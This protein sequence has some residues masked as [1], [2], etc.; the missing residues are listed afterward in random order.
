MTRKDHFPLPFIDKLLERISGHPFYCFLDGYLG[1]FQIKIIVE[2]QEKTTLTCPFGTYAYKRRPF[3]LYNVPATFQRCM[4]SIFN[5]MVERI[6]EVYMDDITI[7]G[8][9]F[10]ECLANLEIVLNRCI[11]KTWCFTGRSAILW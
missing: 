11:E 10:M 9:S 1:Y 6:M 2:D 7:Y 3:S 4:L 5:D 8:G